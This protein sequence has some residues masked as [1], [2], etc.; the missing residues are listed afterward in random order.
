M[1][2][3][4]PLREKISFFFGNFGTDVAQNFIRSYF[5]VF[6]TNILH[7]DP[8]VAGTILLISILWDAINDPLMGMIADRGKQTKWGKYRPYILKSIVPLCVS[9]VVMFAN[10]SSM[11]MAVR[12]LIAG[13]FYILYGMSFTYGQVPYGTLSNV[14]TE[15]SDG[16]AV[17]GTFRDYG[18]N[19]GATI[20][21]A[22]AIGLIMAFSA[23]DTADAGGYFGAAVIVAIVTGVCVLISFLG[24]KEHVAVKSEPVKMKDSFKCLFSCKPALLIAGMFLFSTIGTSFRSAI[25]AYYAEYYLGNM[26]LMGSILTVMFAVPLVGL[27]FVPFLTK[28]LGRKKMF[29]L[30]N[31]WLLLGGVCY[32]IA[33][34]NMVLIYVATILCG[35]CIS[36]INAVVWGAMPDAAEYGEWKTGIRAPGFIFSVALFA[37]KC[38]QAISNYSAGIVLDIANFDSYA[39][40]QAASVGQSVYWSYG[41]FAI[42]PAA[43]AIIII[44]FYKLDQK[45]MDKV[46]AD[47]AATRSIQD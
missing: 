3:K 18:A 28:K 10:T 14:M 17:L 33:Q 31:L 36:F 19:L 35:L 15:D 4:L 24:T 11:P 12:I 6:M 41:L 13:G 43:I 29:I 38:G 46:H 8:G 9:I 47:L 37:L 40:V 23:G 44:S 7:I 39:Q 22:V 5:L 1:E 32:L 2:K 42:I 25:T 45:T 30:G 34:K 21:N 27:F 26:E 20:I 16:R